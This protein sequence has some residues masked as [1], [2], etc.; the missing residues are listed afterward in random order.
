MRML[1]LSLC[2]WKKSC[3]LILCTFPNSN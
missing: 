1:I 2:F 3:W